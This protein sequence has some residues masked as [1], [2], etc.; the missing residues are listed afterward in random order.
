MCS[1]DNRKQKQRSAK[2]KKRAV[3]FG[4]MGAAFPK[5]LRN[6]VILIT[7]HITVKTWSFSL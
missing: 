7:D 1:G 5:Q 6:A 2:K 3:L 4:E